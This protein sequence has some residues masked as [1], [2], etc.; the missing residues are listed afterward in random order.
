MIKS[1]R[2]L[3][4]EVPITPATAVAYEVPKIL[5]LGSFAKPKKL[6]PIA[7]ILHGILER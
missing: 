7:P 1:S 3:Q 4:K 6:F 2:R 5:F